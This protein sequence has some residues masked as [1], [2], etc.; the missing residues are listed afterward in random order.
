MVQ[1]FL[2]G[3]VKMHWS[4]IGVSLQKPDDI[5][6]QDISSRFG[7]HKSR[8][9]GLVTKIMCLIDPAAAK[10]VMGLFSFIFDRS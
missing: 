2:P 5:G 6:Y 9:I 8:P 4:H 7:K 1:S 3:E 10:N